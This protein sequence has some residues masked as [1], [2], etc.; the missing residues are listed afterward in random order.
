MILFKKEISRNTIE[1]IISALFLMIL[2]VIAL[3]AGPKSIAAFLLLMGILINDELAVNFL[4][5]TR[6]SLDYILLQ[7]LF[8]APMLF[9]S[10][11]VTSE[12]IH[13]VF[14]EIALLFH[15]F[16]GWY[17]FSNTLD[18]YQVIEWLK[19]YPYAA[20]LF[21]LPAL[22]TLVW[23][24]FQT[25]SI[26][27]LV[28]LFL[29]TWGMDI[30]GWFV[31]KRWGKHKLWEKVSPKKTIEG[32]IGGMIAAAIL[33]TSAAVIIWDGIGFGH[34][35]LFALMGG[36]AQVGDLVQSKLK[37]QFKIKD[38]SKLIPGHGGVYDR[39][40]SLI[41]LTPFYIVLM[42]VVFIL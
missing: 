20:V 25:F 12:A 40:D 10:Y 22:M 9:F 37:R 42:K 4:R 5:R 17:L 21:T 24:A 39:V 38:S 1:R 3:I 27:L 19:R 26:S 36:I 11:V 7:F 34:F 33:G 41:F 18:K 2:V 8:I 15:G 13:I 14:I 35:L 23:L 31:G 28:V 30:G 32:L 6:L 29:I 16:L